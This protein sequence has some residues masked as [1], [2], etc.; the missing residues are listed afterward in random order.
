MIYNRVVLFGTRS[1]KIFNFSLI[2]RKKDERNIVRNDELH[3]KEKLDF[4]VMPF[5][6]ERVRI[7]P[8]LNPFL[9]EECRNQKR[10]LAGIK[11]TQA[12]YNGK[13]VQD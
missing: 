1:D 7:N 3:Q 11:N 10:I 9:R 2:R 4:T 12:L 8:A 6:R 13:S 5:N